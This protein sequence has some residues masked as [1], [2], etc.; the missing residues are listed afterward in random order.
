MIHILVVAAPVS[1]NDN[2]VN[3]CQIRSLMIP[4]LLF[5]FYY[6]TV[7]QDKLNIIQSVHNIHMYKVR[8]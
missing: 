2:Y 6:Y 7:G 5:Y 8:L 4:F 3:L 1:E